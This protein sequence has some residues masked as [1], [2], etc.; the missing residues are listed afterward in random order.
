M[1]STACSFSLRHESV[2]PPTK[3]KYQYPDCHQLL[4]AYHH[5]FTG[6]YQHVITDNLQQTTK[7]IFVLVPIRLMFEGFE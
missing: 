1:H 6:Y 5:S 4:L 7:L 3:F 2:L